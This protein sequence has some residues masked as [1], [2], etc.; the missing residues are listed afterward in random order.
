MYFLQYTI[1]K[2][3]HIKLA[4]LLELLFWRFHYNYRSSTY[5]FAHDSRRKRN[6]TS[7]QRY[8][9]HSGNAYFKRCFRFKFIG[10]KCEIPR[11]VLPR[12]SA[13]SLLV[14]LIAI[15]VLTLILPNFTTSVSILFIRNPIDFCFYSLSHHLRYFLLVQTVRHRNYFYPITKKK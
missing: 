14:S 11:T 6:L 9:F 5:Y 15:L 1:Q 10:R 2:S 4:N 3:S 8:C 12:T 7:R 13:N